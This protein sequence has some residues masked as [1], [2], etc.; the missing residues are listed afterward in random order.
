MSRLLELFRGRGATLRGLLFVLS[1]TLAVALG[2]VLVTPIVAGHMIIAWGYYY[3]LGVFCLFVHFAWKLARSR[4]EV[5]EGWIRRPGAGGLAILCG[6]LFAVWSDSYTHK[7]LYDEFVIQGTAYEMHLLKQVSTVLRAYNINGTWLTIDPY[8]DKRPYFFP[9]LVS[10]LHDLTGYRVANMFIVNGCCAAALLA[11]LYWF[12]KGVS[13]K[14]PAVFAVA[15][16]A[17]LP[18]FGQ[19]ATGAGMDLHNLT[20]IALVACLSV[21]YLRV[22]SEDRLSLLVLGSV[23][24]TESRYES[25]VFTLPVA[26]V[27]ALGWLKAGRAILPWPVLLAPLLLVPCAWHSRVFAATPVFWQLKEGQ[28]SAFGWRNMAD[29]FRGD[30]DFLFS[31]G[32]GYANSLFLSALGVLGLCWLAYRAWRWLRVEGR[33][34]LSAEAK[35]GLVF[36]AGVGA[37]FLVLLFYWWAKF[38]DLMA[39][40]FSLP[41]S[42]AFA[43]LGAAMIAAF[44]KWGERALRVAWLGLAVWFVT[45]GMSAINLRFYTVANLGMKELAWERSFVNA[46][47]GPVL[48]I[49]NKS[50]I[51]FV[52]WHIEVVL[53]SVAALKGDDIRYH[54]GQGTFSEVIVSQAIRPITDDGQAGV[55]PADVLPPSFHLVTIAEKRFGGRWDRLSRVV[56]VDPSPHGPTKEKDQVPSDPTPLRSISRLQSRREPSVA[57]LTSSALRR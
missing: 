29:N 30:V 46:R 57:S 53:N 20:M 15:S 11:L 1:G 36:G 50:T 37:H 27:V 38:D 22:P 35:V 31:P 44:G 14:G 16:M 2:F 18:L 55:D 6:V 42:L 23:L 19:N 26:V 43:V 52:L 25:A 3:I 51:P 40:R 8:L 34:P 5:I 13:G 4:Q 12:A 56:S 41:L 45:C 28:T 9:F 48:F 17:M 10:L 49:S 7:I 33:P 32:P 54:M 47:P 39:A 24:L 21:L